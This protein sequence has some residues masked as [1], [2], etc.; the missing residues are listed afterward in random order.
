M[1]GRTFV[2]G[3]IHGDLPALRKVLGRMPRP[4][5]GDTLVFLGDYLDRGPSSAGVVDFLRNVLPRHTQARIVLLRGNHEDAWVKVMDGAWP[6]FVL[7]PGNGCL[8]TMQSFLGEPVSRLGTAAT[9]AQMERL[10]RAEFFPPS[11]ARWLRELP[12]YYEDEHAIYV[13]AG[14]PI[15]PDGGFV[16][17]AEAVGKQRVALLWIRDPRFFRDY[18][19]KRVVVGHTGTSRLPPE[20]SDYTPDDPNDL[21]YGPSVIGLDTGAGK[22]GFLT[23]LELPAGTVYESRDRGA[24]A[25]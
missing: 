5:A 16:H 19:G 25:S 1:P 13:H 24:S 15:A 21:W 7:P 17:P 22:R 10:V 11:V 20:L 9:F 12:D 18:R 8:Q 14:L 3:D 2:I 4:D 23:A 6:D